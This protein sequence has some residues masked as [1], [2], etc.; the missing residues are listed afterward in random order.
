MSCDHGELHAQMSL[1]SLTSWFNL[2]IH[3]MAQNMRLVEPLNQ[4]FSNLTSYLLEVTPPHKELEENKV[5]SYRN[6]MS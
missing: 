3:S 1:R 6:Y 5:V 4:S 2:S